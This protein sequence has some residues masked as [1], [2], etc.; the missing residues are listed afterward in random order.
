HDL[1]Q[2][3]SRAGSGSLSVRRAEPKLGSFDHPQNP[4]FYLLIEAIDHKELPSACPRLISAQSF[5]A[6][7][8]LSHSVQECRFVSLADPLASVVQRSR[9][10]NTNSLTSKT[11]PEPG[12]TQGSTSRKPVL[13]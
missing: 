8:F 6:S 10:G 4:I 12:D 9:I 7:K 2:V 13:W 5:F 3:Q 1:E 11:C